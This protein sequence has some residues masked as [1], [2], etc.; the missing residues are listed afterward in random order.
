MELRAE[1]CLE[2]RVP[3]P[4]LAVL[5]LSTSLNLVSS[6]LSYSFVQLSDNPNVLFITV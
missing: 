3:I 6:P 1:K 4:R 2:Y 5:F